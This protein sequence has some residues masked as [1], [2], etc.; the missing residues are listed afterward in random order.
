MEKG[1]QIRIYLV[2][3]RELSFKVRSLE[4]F[5]KSLKN[6]AYIDVYNAQHK[7]RGGITQIGTIDVTINKN[8][9]EM[10]EI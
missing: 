7:N 3:G 1:R 8:N 10:V 9:I 4:D 5:K 6:K 2:S